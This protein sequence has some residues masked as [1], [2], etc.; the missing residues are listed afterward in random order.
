[1]DN[2]A[3]GDTTAAQRATASRVRRARGM[4]IGSWAW[5]GAM[6][7]LVARGQGWWDIGTAGAGMSASGAAALYWGLCTACWIA[8]IAFFWPQLRM[9]STAPHARVTDRE[10]RHFYNQETH[11]D[12]N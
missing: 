3:A 12:A 9:W 7:L 2:D 11:R 1:M 10:I 4:F 5:L 6:V 8:T